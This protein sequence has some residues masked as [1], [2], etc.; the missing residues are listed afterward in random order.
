M[1]SS[2]F[3]QKAKYVIVL[4]AV[5]LF[6]P[7][8][9]FAQSISITPNS[10]N[11]PVGKSFTLRVAVS[12]PNQ[13][14][15]AFAGTV[16]FPKDKLQ[17]VSLSK[18][19]SIVSVWVADPIFSNEEGLV[20]FEG[21]ALN[22]GFI[23]VSGKILSINFKS[24]ARGDATVTVTN[25]SVLANDGTGTNVLNGISP[26]MITIG[27]DT[28]S[29]LVPK[30]VTVDQVKISSITH[31]DERKWYP[32]GSAKFSW[33][34]P[35]GA[36]KSFVSL[37]RDVSAQPKKIYDSVLSVKEIAGIEDGT[38]YFHLA[39]GTKDSKGSVSTY[40]INVDTVAPS[41]FSVKEIPRKDTANPKVQFAFSAT[42]ETSGIDKYDIS[43]DSGS[44][45]GWRDPGDGVFETEALSPGRHT[46]SVKAY[47]EAGNY[48]PAT[49]D[50]YVSGVD[51][52]TIISFTDR[53]ASSDT[54]SVSGRTYPNASVGLYMNV[55][56][57]EYEFARTTSGDDGLFKVSW[58]PNPISS[59]TIVLDSKNPTSLK[60][61]IFDAWVDAAV[62]GVKTYPS[63]RVQVV[64]DA[65]FSVALSKSLFEVSM[66]LMPAIAMMVVAILIALYG[67]RKV[68]S[69]KKAVAVEASEAE[70]ILHKS[71]NILREDIAEYRAAVENAKTRRRITKVESELV[72]RLNDNLAQA[73]RAIKK[74]VKDIEHITE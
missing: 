23:G 41:S 67:T 58:K 16:S 63:R 60:D 33:I 6:L 2:N 54:V 26:S 69:F 53:V 25:A 18:T 20:S 32:T 27:G 42:D 74:E 39:L 28:A 29:T 17:V 61:G 43:I 10:A 36:T 72:A 52:P 62:G 66:Y 65:P 70:D 30:K 7:H 14:V 11:Q 19:D 48:T 71:F 59:D 46:L 73:E 9:L 44:V 40:R 12:S 45:V 51:A 64:V 24:I 56:G 68:L 49:T 1:V 37:D 35:L 34:P 47:D 8:Y 57:K 31:P 15:N 55:L 5:C 22:P 3:F 38:W 50:F 13:A 4:C 21:V